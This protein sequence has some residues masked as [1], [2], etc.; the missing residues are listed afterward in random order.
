MNGR[1]AREV[2]RER[3]RLDKQNEAAV[4]G[5]PQEERS[6]LMAALASPEAQELQDLVAEM[7]TAYPE[8]VLQAMMR[9]YNLAKS[10]PDACQ[11]CGD[12]P[13]SEVSWKSG[14]GG[15]KG[16]LCDDCIQIQQAM[17]GKGDELIK[18]SGVSG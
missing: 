15:G 7:R 10:G 3:E 17:Y 6:A 12:L 16:R 8:P 14:W 5:M 1:R 9:G 11:I 4:L 2:R 18:T 13:A